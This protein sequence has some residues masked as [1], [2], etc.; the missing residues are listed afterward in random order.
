MR[1]RS[2]A[3]LLITA[4]LL[5]CT[6]QGD[7]SAATTNTDVSPNPSVT[8][9]TATTT[10]RE[11][12]IVR[13]DFVVGLF[14]GAELSEADYQG[15]FTADFIGAVPYDEFTGVLA[16]L[17][18]QG[19]NW[20]ITGFE[21]RDDLSATVLA[22]PEEGEGVRLQL[23]LE[24]VAPFRIAGL[25]V[26]PAEP[27]TLENP[28]ADL[29]AGIARLEEIGTT[30][31]LAADVIDGQCVPIES[32]RADEPAPIAS[33]FKLYVLGAL[34]DAVAAGDIAWDDE[35]VIS[36]DLKS[37]PSGILQDEDAGAIFTVREVAE[38]MISISDNTATDHLIDL[39]GRE[40]VEAAF[41]EAG[42]AD[43][44]LNIPLMNTLDLAALKVGPASGLSVQWLEADERGRRALLDQVSDLTPADIPIAEFQDPIL[45]DQIE[46]FASP[47]DLCRAM[48]WLGDKGEP[49]TQILSINPGV[50]AEDGLFDSIW[51]KGGSEPGLVT[52]AWLVKTPDGRQFFLAGSVVDPEQPIDERETVL[53]LSSL[54]DLLASP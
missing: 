8:A 46:W 4:L 11:P 41:S 44:S 21:E 18:T 47:E 38:L 16:D 31:F 27:P 40:S 9:P 14:N 36:E 35:V 29:A 48:M 28:P 15:T 3:L 33:A 45:P 17:T 42:M 26:Q 20:A 37:I 5:G 24:N 52:M 22:A 25:L 32:V 7:G 23:A 53:L 19:S 43:P 12:L 34:A 30:R 13:L 2:R 50:P 10:T 39:L 49:T 54:R 51:F 6:T 1:V